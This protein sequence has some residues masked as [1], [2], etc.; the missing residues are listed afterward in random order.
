[1]FFFVFVLKTDWRTFDDSRVADCN[2]IVTS[3]AYILFYKRR[4]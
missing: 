2:N 3:D 1:M 4:D